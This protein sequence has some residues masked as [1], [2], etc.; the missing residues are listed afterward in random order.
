MLGI[1]HE[2]CEKLDLDHQ[3]IGR[4]E[5]RFIAVRRKSNFNVVKNKRQKI[6]HSSQ[7]NKET[8]DRRNR[9]QK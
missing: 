6:S 3:S 9:K 8:R 2:C 5:D 7:S 1:I 4:G